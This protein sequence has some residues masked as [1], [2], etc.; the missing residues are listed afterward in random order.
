LKNAVIARGKGINKPTADRIARLMTE[1]DI[2]KVMAF[3]KSH[4]GR[5]FVKKVG[6]HL[7]PSD[8]MALIRASAG[9]G[10]ESVGE[11]TIGTIPQ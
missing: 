9:L 6:G 8:Q 10:G 2:P 7:E 1:Q 11:A 3:L 5:K 4:A